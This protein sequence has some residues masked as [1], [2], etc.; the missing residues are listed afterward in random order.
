[1]IAEG[2]RVSADARLLQGSVEVDTSTLTGESVPVV[3]AAGADDGGG[4]F[5]DA[6]D[7]VFSG[8]T[9]TAG[10][11]TPS[12]S[13]PGCTRSSAASP[14][15]RS[16]RAGREPARARGPAGRV[17]HR[18]RRG[19]DRARVPS[20]RHARRRVVVL[21]RG[22]VRDRVARRQ[23]ARGLLPTITLA[24]GVGV[25][26]LARQGALVKRLSAVETLGSTTVICTDKTGTL[27]ENRMHVV[28]SGR[29][30]DVD[31]E[32]PDAPTPRV[33]TPTSGRSARVALARCTSADD[34]RRPTRCVRVGDPTETALL[35]AAR[36]SAPTSTGRPA[37][38][39]PRGVPLRPAL[40]LMSTVDESTARCG[41]TRRERPKRCSPAA[42]PCSNPTEPNSR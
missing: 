40:K 25:R 16:S 27:T 22:G 19:R 6:T 10:D 21:G 3:R 33:R 41:C 4:G 18:A 24:L 23:R 29:P 17:D 26:V 1:V 37:S 13:R 2:D 15:C 14:R 7:L 35:L 36:R 32:D 8:A 11:G 9:C 20:A 28:A 38:V 34:R 31:L 39:V 5:L 42:P 12:C 30:G